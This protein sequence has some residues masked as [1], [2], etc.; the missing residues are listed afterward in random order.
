MTAR[1]LAA[2]VAAAVVADMVLARFARTT[3]FRRCALCGQVRE[4]TVR[5][6]SYTCRTCGTRH[7]PEVT[8]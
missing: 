6:D 4:C 5:P 3:A 8:L 1:V 7:T 2:I